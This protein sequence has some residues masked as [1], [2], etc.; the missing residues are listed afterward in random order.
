MRSSL[1]HRLTIINTLLILMAAVLGLMVVII[2]RSYIPPS[3][4][5]FVKNELFG[6]RF[7][8]AVV[9]VVDESAM[10]E[11]VLPRFDI[12]F[13]S[14]VRRELSLLINHLRKKTYQEE[15]DK[16][17][18]PATFYHDGYSY[19]VKIRIRGDTSSHWES[20]KISWRVKFKKNDT[21]NGL[22]SL[23]LIIP[24][25]RSYESEHIFYKLAKKSGLL[26]PDSGYAL[27]NVNGV[28]MGLY[29][30]IEDFDLRM[31]E[32]NKRSGEFFVENN[33]WLA[34]RINRL[35]LF[36]YDQRDRD[37]QQ[38]DFLPSSYKP[39]IQAGFSTAVAMG[40]WQEFLELVRNSDLQTLE[41][42]I[43]LYM[44]VEKFAQWSALNWLSGSTH[45][46]LLHNSRWFYDF[47]TGL[48]EPIIWDV[49]ATRIS[50]WRFDRERPTTDIGT[51]EVQKQVGRLIERLL[52][53][54]TIQRLRNEALW[55]MLNDPEFDLESLSVDLF[56]QLRPFLAQGAAAEKYS[57]ITK[58]F[59]DRLDAYRENKKVLRGNLQFTH[60]FVDVLMT[61]SERYARVLFTI[62][63]NSISPLLL[64]SLKI[65][66]FSGE[67]GKRVE[68][69]LTPPGKGS[70][71]LPVVGTFVDGSLEVAF[72]GLE[73]WS[74][75][76]RHLN[77]DLTEW[78][79]EFRLPGGT[80]DLDQVMARD[81]TITLNLENG[82]TGKSIE[83][84]SIH[85][86]GPSI[87]PDK[88]ERRALRTSPQEFMDASGLAFRIEG[89][90][91]ILGQGIYNI[92]QDIILPRGYGLRLEAGATL[93]LGSGVDISTD[94]PLRVL[95]RQDAPVT[96]EALDPTKPWGSLAVIKAPTSSTVEFLHISGGSENWINGTYCSGQLCFYSS[97]V[98]IN[99]SLVADATAD[100][101]L[102]VKNAQ[103]NI[104]NTRFI[105]NVSDGFDGDWVTGIVRNSIFKGNRDDG[106]DLSG[107]RVV[108]ENSLFSG[109]GDKA[110]SA[111]E[112]S[113]VVLL[114]NVFRDSGYGVVSK[115]LSVTHIF[116]SVFIRNNIAFSAVQKKDFFGGGKGVLV[117]SLLWNNHQDFIVDD[118]SALELVRVGRN[119]LALMTGVTG[120][121]VTV[122]DI[123]ELYTDDGGEGVRFTGPEDSPFSKG[124]ASWPKVP[125]EGVVLPLLSSR[126]IGLVR[127]VLD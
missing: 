6:S 96:I 94:H 123:G 95:G 53:V 32:K 16:K 19:D 122:D 114:N 1:Y 49:G 97:D 65:P 73:L 23:N 33:S 36:N 70:H 111:G 85:V 42:D 2:F 100:D 93:R 14:S 120:T 104:E 75:R 8:H 58:S 66:G 108:I 7:V 127:N 116:S 118:K 10:P 21:F 106:I 35:G 72:N 121:L 5:A 79:V 81:A 105:N 61:K 46:Q 113:V 9:S 101:G 26:V 86:F 43:E 39:S 54:P 117:S 80:I 115:D 92:F 28:D 107:S 110:V 30:M 90:E 89:K 69:F 60:V 59:S 31:L 125:I 41:K 98:R 78:K 99:N 77:L 112:K 20:D 64:K 83:N 13:R 57:V 68:V 91:I 119:N 37:K 38:L 82:I 124:P 84:T 11:M 67:P 88:V 40:K 34:S 47:T 62:V 15:K 17:W 48:V 87:A 4:A 74:R 24:A 109:M 102:N 18:F 56:K 63:P 12:K 51:F 71:S 55:A 29:F 76:T 50:P 44:D 103:V 25:D 3:I 126:P 22:R 52:R 27:V 45:S